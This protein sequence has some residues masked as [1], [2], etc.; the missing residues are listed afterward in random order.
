MRIAWM[1][2]LVFAGWLGAVPCVRA[3]V[4]TTAEK[5]AGPQVGT[6][7]VKPVPFS[8]FQN[9]LS[10]AVDLRTALKPDARKRSLAKKA[11]LEAKV[12]ADTATLQ[13][14]INLSAYLIGLGEYTEAIALLQPI[15]ADRSQPPNFMVFANLGTAFQ[16][17]GE[18]QRADDCLVEVRDL[19]KTAQPGDGLTKEQLDW[20]RE[21]E[22]YQL[23]LVRKRRKEA[24]Q[25]QGG[26]S[27]KVE[28]VD[29]LFG[30]RFV[31]PSGQYEAGKLADEEKAKLPKN[32]QAI[33]QQ[34]LLWVPN[35]IQTDS[36]LYWLYG[37]LLNARGDF[38]DAWKV[39]DTCSDALSFHPAALRE[40][41]QVLAAAL[42]PPPAPP[43][44]PSVLPPMQQ[45]VL[46]GAG[47]GVVLLLLGYL[48]F[49]E[50]RRRKQ[51]S[52]RS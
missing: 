28:T 1:V 31:G 51:A 41:H 9:D 30:V 37:E 12:K 29:D 27:R 46:V 2:A 5:P 17:T 35:G 49:R 40:H 44:P 32:A 19:L 4:Y 20:Y 50:M 36:R 25:A 11:E 52:V 13:D 38:K 18:L 7:G 23:L 3:G 26:A 14:K 34:L 48:Q 39:L 22:K 21:V 6:D 10:D 47:V 24:A 16:I 42:P 15:T 45:M 43:P 33:V 8:S